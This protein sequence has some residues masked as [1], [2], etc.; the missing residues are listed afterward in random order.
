MTTPDPESLPPVDPQPAPAVDPE[1]QQAVYEQVQ[2][3]R[4]RRLLLFLLLLL[5]L[6]LACVGYFFFRYLTR[7]QPLPE[8]LPDAISQNIYYPPT[9]Q[10]SIPDVNRPIG[11]AVSPD[12]QRIYVTESE[13]ERSIKMFDRDGNLVLSF[14]PPGTNPNTRDLA[15]LAVDATGRVY[16]QRHLQPCRSHL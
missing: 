1:V 9:Y 11:V 7:P 8:M 15:Y 4:K 3:E 16:R 10:F 14:S 12:G 2:D 6:M 13:G 5:L